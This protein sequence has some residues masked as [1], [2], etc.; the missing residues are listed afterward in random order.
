M[1]ALAAIHLGAD[2]YLTFNGLDEEC[3]PLGKPEADPSPPAFP[4]RVKTFRYACALFEAE[5]QR[6]RMKA[7]VMG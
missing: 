3:R 5:Q 1:L 7:G 2:P 6:E 4:A